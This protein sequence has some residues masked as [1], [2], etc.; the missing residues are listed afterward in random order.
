MIGYLGNL[1]CIGGILLIGAWQ[2]FSVARFFYRVI[3]Q[4]NVA[5]PFPWLSFAFVLLIF[6][7]VGSM[8]VVMV[9]DAL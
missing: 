4:P 2:F 5:H 7:V 1:V 8:V 9:L 3:R 6:Y